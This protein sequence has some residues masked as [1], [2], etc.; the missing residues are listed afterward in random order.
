MPMLPRISLITPSFQQAPFLEECLASVQVQDGVEVEHIVVDGGSTDGSADIIAR[1]AGRL[2]WWC[3]EKDDGQSHAINKG[4]AHATG[5]VFGWINSDDAL[6]P[7]ALH[8]V[9]QAFAAD[10]TLLVFGGQRVLRFADGSERVAPLD[11]HHHPDRLF[12]AP[13]INQQSTFYRLD[14]VRAVGGVD[15]AMHYAM[16]HELWLR[17]LFHSGADHLRFEPVPLAVFR[18]HDAMKSRATDRAFTGEVAGVLHGLCIGAGLPE[19]AEV[20]RIGHRWPEHMRRIPVGPDHADLV[21]RMVLYFLLKWHHVVHTETGFRMMRTLLSSGAIDDAITD[22]Q[23]RAWLTTLK[24]QL[25]VP[26]WWA[27]RLRRKWMHLTR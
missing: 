24:A 2:A 11:D 14:A 19:L 16:D 22:D 21:R 18:V 12:I 7:G 25:R 9:S 1:H 10:P 17:L 20:L 5:A 3:S 15:P 27:F 23:Q 26:G 6:L 8:R 4:L 13:K